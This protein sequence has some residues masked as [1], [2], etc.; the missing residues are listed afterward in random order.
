MKVKIKVSDIAEAMSGKELGFKELILEAEP[1]SEPEEDWEHRLVGLM[2]E[3]SV[4]SKGNFPIENFI[5][6]EI[7]SKLADDVIKSCCPDM[8]A[9]ELVC[10][11]RDRWLGRDK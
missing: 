6:T 5:R 4:H 11:V 7:I 3:Y 1:V 2:R 9:E 8:G 10:E